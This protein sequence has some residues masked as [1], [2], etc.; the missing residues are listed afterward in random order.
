MK[1][2]SSFEKE[3]GERALLRFALS[4]SRAPK[5]PRPLLSLC[6]AGAPLTR[7][8]GGSTS[9][10]RGFWVCGVAAVKVSA[11]RKKVEQSE[12]AAEKKKVKQK[13]IS[14]QN[15]RLFPPPP[16]PEQFEL[17]EEQAL[18]AL[19][20]SLPLSRPYT[21]AFPLAQ[22][23]DKDQR[24][25]FTPE[26]GP[27]SDGRVSPAR[28]G[29]RLDAGVGVVDALLFFLHVP[30]RRRLRGAPPELR[31]APLGAPQSKAVHFC[32]RRE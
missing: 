9:M 20:L 1:E 29:R 22:G 5:N 15:L 24:S 17:R 10:A 2:V 12:A 32:G 3:A 16:P 14:F 6:S 25:Q 13:K 30:R 4:L 21:N 31:V 8:T 28:P 23:D 18:P 27:R 26:G 19:S 11:A 7:V